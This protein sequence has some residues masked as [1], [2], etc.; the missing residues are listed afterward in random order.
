M[1]K[2]VPNS[3][4]EKQVT[5]AIYTRCHVHKP[6]RKQNKTYVRGKGISGTIIKKNNGITNILK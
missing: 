3:K 5:E 6:Q 2:C 1:H 4:P